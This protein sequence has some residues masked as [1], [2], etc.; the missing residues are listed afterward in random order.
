[1]NWIWSSVS[2]VISS[3]ISYFIAKHVLKKNLKSSLYIDELKE[4]KEILKYSL[5]PVNASEPTLMQRSSIGI[6]YDNSGYRNKIQNLSLNDPELKALLKDYLENVDKYN[7]EYFEY[8]KKHRAADVFSQDTSNPNELKEVLSTYKQ[9]LFS[10]YQR[11]N[12]R[13]EKII[14]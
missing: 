6:L 12:L 3:I 1:M 9:N 2:V 11:I 14:I 7:H 4:I 13:I 10:L 5:E 8:Q